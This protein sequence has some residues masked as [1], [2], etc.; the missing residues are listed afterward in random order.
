MNETFIL[1]TGDVK[2]VAFFVVRTTKGGGIT[3]VPQLKV[4]LFGFT[5]IR[6]AEIEN[7]NENK[8]IP[9]KVYI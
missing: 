2:K 3:P 8:K 6:S 1:I 5:L 4:L 9:K 7:V